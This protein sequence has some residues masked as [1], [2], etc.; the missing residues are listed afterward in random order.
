MKYMLM[1]Y[2][3]EVA[4]SNIPP[5]EMKGFMD[6]LYAY[7]EALRS[8]VPLDDQDTA[9]WNLAQIR[10]AEALMKDA[11]RME[12][13]GRFQVEAAIQ[14]AHGARRLHG[15]DN[16]SDI[17]ALYDVLLASSKKWICALMSRAALEGLLFVMTEGPP[18]ER[19]VSLRL[20]IRRRVL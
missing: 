7:R 19:V 17:V 13:S 12:D 2:A 10:Q 9:L 16:W 14:S 18:R 8:Y 11:N 3:D 6:Q 4:G 20:T 1:L 5:E 15:L